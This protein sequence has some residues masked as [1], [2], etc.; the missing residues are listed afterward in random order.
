MRFQSLIADFKGK[1]KGPLDKKVG[2][3]LLG[4]G[5]VAIWV[6]ALAYGVGAA[7]RYESTPGRAA[8]NVPPLGPSQE[9]EWTSV[10]VAHPQCPCTTASLRALRSVMAKHSGVLSCRIVFAG[11][12]PADVSKNMEVANSIPGA[13]V[14][15]M[16]ADEAER[17]YHAYTSGQTF[18]YRPSGQLA[19]SGGITPGRGVDQP[20]YAL[21]LFST[22]FSERGQMRETPV[23]G[24]QIGEPE[25]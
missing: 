4:T 10:M 25:N 19:F 21:D 16:K 8:S 22:I 15:W 12:R 1:Q 24:C 13:T 18:I 23:F 3:I 9:R 5:V 7:M 20:R 6:V 2:K 11:A 17:V 14:E